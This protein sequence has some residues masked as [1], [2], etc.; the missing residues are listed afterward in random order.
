M[1]QVGLGHGT[2]PD[3]PGRAAAL[4]L[5]KLRALAH[6]GD[7]H[8]VT[9]QR[10]PV[11]R[12]AQPL[13][14][15]LKVLADLEDGVALDVE[16]LEVRE[17]TSRDPAAQVVRLDQPKQSRRSRTIWSLGTRSAASVLNWRTTTAYERVVTP[18]V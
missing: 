14:R 13:A 6:L 3:G 8:D 1:R 15:I 16:C 17:S 10:E 7:E 9:V 11:R 5:C 4:A 18:P 2:L 12:A